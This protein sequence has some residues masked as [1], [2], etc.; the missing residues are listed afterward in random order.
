MSES[1]FFHFSTSS[2]KARVLEAAGAIGGLVMDNVAGTTGGNNNNAA[3][4]APLFAMSGD[5][6]DDVAIP[7]VFL[8]SE[9]AKVV[10]ARLQEAVEAD[11]KMVVTLSEAP[12][13]GEF[14]SHIC[15]ERKKN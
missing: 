14:I 10:A 11:Q 9:D 3:A 1:F 2:E 13:H 6:T 12:E 15:V 7:T 5:G 4:A 8:F